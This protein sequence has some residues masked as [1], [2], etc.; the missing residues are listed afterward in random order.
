[1]PAPETADLPD[2]YGADGR[3]TDPDPVFAGHAD[4]WRT[5]LRALAA[6]TVGA[7]A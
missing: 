1:M 4:E 5:A 3:L 2:A 6:V 7:G